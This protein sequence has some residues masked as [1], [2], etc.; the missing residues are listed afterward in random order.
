MTDLERALFTEAHLRILAA[1]AVPTGF[2]WELGVRSVTD[3]AELP[4]GTPSYWSSLLPALLFPWTGI[5]GHI[6]WQLRPDTPRAFTLGGDAAKYLSR[7]KEDGFVSTPWV[8]RRP[9]GSGSVVFVEGTKQALSVAAH[10]PAGYGVVGLT[11][12]WGYSDR[13]FASA[14]LGLARGRAAIICMD[15]DYADKRGVWD[16]AERMAGQLLSLENA[17]SVRV[18][19]LPVSGDKGIDDVLADRVEADRGRTLAAL[20]DGA[21]EE[22]F[23]KSRAPRKRADPTD[24]FDPVTGFRAQTAAHTLVSHS[25]MALTRDHQVAIYDTRKGV[26]RAGEGGSAFEGTVAGLLGEQHRSSYVTTV[27]QSLYHVLADTRIPEKISSPRLNVSNGLLDVTT[28]ELHAHTPEHLSMV[29]LPVA[30]PGCADE[31][32]CPT[33]VQWLTDCIG[34]DQL[35]GLEEAAGAMF[36]PRFTPSKALMLFGPSR[37]GKSTFLRL[38]E[39][40]AGDENV[41]AESLHALA[42]DQFAAANV[43]GKILNSSADLSAKDV[44]DI[45]FFKMMTG[46]DLIKGN[47]KYG[48]QFSFRNKALFAFSA[49]TLPT[50]SESS[51]AYVERVHPVKFGRSFAGRE[52]PAIELRMRAELPGILVRLVYAAQRRRQRGADLPVVAA[53]RQEFETRSN[54]V[55]DWTA[56]CAQTQLLQAPKSATPGRTTIEL[57]TAYSL[58]MDASRRKPLGR[59]KFADVL[60][61]MAPDVQQ[62]ADSSKVRRW[63]LIVKPQAEWDD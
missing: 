20:L 50:V 36:D 6:E 35:D 12:C 10:A 43:Y 42:D 57:H 45:S 62:Y 16:A 34:A 21:V 5:D 41:S 46:D 8:L 11:G 28:G 15:A 61:G 40:L 51:R 30:W 27:R 53:V 14:A 19:K 9:E 2:A 1:S 58:W 26:Y 32:A 49:N 38:L 22:K 18:V 39:A 4:V 48:R 31:A 3:P 24:L 54:S 44:S 33:Y 37:S 13:G 63:N 25:P 7:G 17:T 56:R 23:P 55:A 60:R 29:Q 52:D 47:R 59:T